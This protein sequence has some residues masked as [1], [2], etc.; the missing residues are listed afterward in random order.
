[1]R[2][3]LILLVILFLGCESTDATTTQATDLPRIR[4]SL[5]FSLNGEH[6][7]GACTFQRKSTFKLLANVQAKTRH[8]V[9]QSCHRLAV[10][11]SKSPFEYRYTPSYWLENMGSCVLF[12]T[13][14]RQDGKR[15]MGIADFTGNERAKATLH[16]NGK[17]TNSLE[18]ASFCQ[19]KVGLVQ[20]I[21]F[22]QPAT[23]Y[24]SDRCPTPVK[25]GNGSRWEYGI[26]AGLCSYLFVLRDGTRHRHTTWG[27]TDVA[28]DP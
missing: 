27:F 21:W 7:E 25:G 22:E 14:I 8:V 4:A 10:L 2:L 12:V 19:S 20:A 15:E 1:M 16:C 26:G 28:V 17:R 11:P 18:G 24:S 5:P 9:L 23:V 13:A 6:C 3:P